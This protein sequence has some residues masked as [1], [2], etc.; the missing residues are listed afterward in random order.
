MFILVLRYVKPL[1]EVDKELTSHVKYLDKYYSL[2]K[3]ICSDRRNPRI[4]GILY[5][6]FIFC[7]K[8]IIKNLTG[9]YRIIS[10]SLK[11]PIIITYNTFY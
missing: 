3:F 11:S 10:N 6:F 4:G 5:F 7:I 1:D 8:E 9:Y 2:Q